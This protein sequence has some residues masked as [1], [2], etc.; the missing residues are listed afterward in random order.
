VAEP[1]PTV[2]QRIGVALCA[3]PCAVFITIVFN[4]GAQLR[5]IVAVIFLVSF[6]ACYLVWYWIFFTRSEEL[7]KK[8]PISSKELQRKTKE[9]YDGL[10]RQ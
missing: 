9:F 8:L 2:V 6:C 3:L 5:P 7:K 4:L 10:P 1:R